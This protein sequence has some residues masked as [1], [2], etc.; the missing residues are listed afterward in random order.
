MVLNSSSGI[1]LSRRAPSKRDIGEFITLHDVPSQMGELFGGD[2]LEQ[3][4]A[5]PPV[6]EE[7]YMAVHMESGAWLESGVVLADSGLLDIKSACTP[8]SLGFAEAFE[9]NL[10][11]EDILAPHV[12]K[13]TT[14]PGTEGSIRDLQ[15]ALAD[16]EIGDSQT[17]VFHETFRVILAKQGCRDH[18]LEAD[19]EV[20]VCCLVVHF[21][22]ILEVSSKLG[23]RLDVRQVGHI[24]D[25]LEACVFGV[26]KEL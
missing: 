6:L 18:K 13:S 23:R 25:R 16:K 5:C 26:G 11:A 20:V 17:E 2:T 8:F 1:T 4:Q 12:S 15:G 9:S 24:L 22:Q 10:E 7:I 14:N 19:S 21:L 3:P